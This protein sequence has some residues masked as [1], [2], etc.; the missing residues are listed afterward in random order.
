M[1]DDNDI[2][3]HILAQ[4]L[5]VC[6]SNAVWPSLLVLSSMSGGLDHL[7]QLAPGHPIVAD[8]VL[9]AIIF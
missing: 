2:V 7:Q 6:A 3:V 5:G 4:V 1:P 9:L 8:P